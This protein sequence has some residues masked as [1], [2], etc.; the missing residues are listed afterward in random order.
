MRDIFA[1]ALVL[2]SAVGCAGVDDGAE[3]EGDLSADGA[4]S[5]L[6][7]GVYV[8]KVAH[9][10]QCIDVSGSSKE[11]SAKVQ[12]WGCNG[13]GAQSFQ[14]TSVGDDYVKIVNTNSGKALDVK[15][16]STAAGTALLQ[17]DYWGG[18]NQQFRIEAAGD[19]RFKI[20][21]RHSGQAL[22]IWQSS[23]SA[24]AALVQ[25]PSNDGP[26]Q[27]F[28]FERK[29]G[30]AAPPATWKEHWFEHNE[31]LSLVDYN[32][33]VAL[34]FDARVNRA[35]TEW[36]LPFSTKMWQYTKEKYGSFGT[37]RLFL[38][39]HE[40]NY[41]GGHPSTYLDA[42]HDNRNVS[43][44]GPGPWNNQGYGLPSHEVSH[45]VEGAS[46]GVRGS[47]AFGLWGDSKWAEFYQ[48]D[49]YVGLG[50]TAEAERVYNE[51]INKADNFPRNGTRWFRDW[52]FPLWRDH[53]HV[54]VMANYFKLLSENFPKNGQAYARDLNWG[55][56]I[57]FMSGAAGTNLQPLASQAFGWPADWQSQFDQAR[58]TFSQI[59]Y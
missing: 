32:D 24:G 25:W 9:S 22:D 6:A 30:L 56:Y 44:C 1:F 53:G 7:D 54:Q 39:F 2:F 13:S 34:Y 29:G 23:Q 52:F 19:G 26:N 18:Q 20:T 59:R 8:I 15:D 57:H 42:S 27:R 45:I 48:Y 33:D 5:S 46:R 47:P 10:G 40:G 31:L 4:L 37:D 43:D 28:T 35:G 49:L 55:E 3:G 36:L 58:A 14:V 41:S 38:V 50:M 16:I 21:A 12:Q 51:F 17:Y 11:N